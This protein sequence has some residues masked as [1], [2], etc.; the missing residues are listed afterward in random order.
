MNKLHTQ[1]NQEDRG[2]TWWR[3]M[4]ELLEN[5]GGVRV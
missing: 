4:L 2:E 3:F 1:G 5:M